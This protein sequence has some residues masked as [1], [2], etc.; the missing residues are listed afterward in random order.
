MIRNVY[1]SPVKLE[2][3]RQTVKKYSN[4]TFQEKSIQWESSSSMRSDGHD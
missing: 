3:S 1:L 4:V 2:Y